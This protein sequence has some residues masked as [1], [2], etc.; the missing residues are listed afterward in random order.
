MKSYIKDLL[1]PKEIGRTTGGIIGT[2]LY[3]AGMNLFV[4]PVGVYSGG[5]M[6]ICQIIRTLLVEYLN[7]P[8]ENFDI[9][10]IIYY[11]VNIPIFFIAYK[12]MGKQF[13][14]KTVIC[15]TTMTLFLSTIP[16]PKQ[17]LLTDDILTSCLIGGIISGVGCGL[18]LMMGG[19]GGGMDIISLYFIKKKG[20]FSV[21]KVNLAVNLILYSICFFLFDFTI[22]IYSIIFAAVSSVAVDK[23][24]SQNINVEVIIITRK[25]LRELQLEVMS[26]LGRGITKWNSMGAYTQEG[27]EILYIILSKYEISQLKRMVHK[28]DKDAFIVVKEG[29]YVEGNYLR[30]L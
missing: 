15:M 21:G 18:T 13:F 2:F 11:L 5:I 26:Q 24:H 28:Y 16:I 30:K 20:N 12:T 17:I 9:A 25:N 7:L 19:S 4:I 27:S 1:K 22:V 14:I 23:I 8:F 29:V 10:G 3:A 6:G